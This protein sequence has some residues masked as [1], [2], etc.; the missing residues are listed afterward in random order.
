MSLVWDIRGEAGRLFVATE[1]YVATSAPLRTGTLPVVGRLPD[2]RHLTG[3]LGM[4]RLVHLL[5]AC[6]GSAT[7]LPGGAFDS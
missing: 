7:A 3:S 6:H 5:D 2:P 4:S 1:C